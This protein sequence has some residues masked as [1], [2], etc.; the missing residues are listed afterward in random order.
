MFLANDILMAASTRVFIEPVV[1]TTLGTGVVAPGIVTITPPSMVAIYNGAMMVVDFGHHS[2]GSEQEV[3][4][5]SNVTA[6]TFQATF[7][8]P[9]LGSALL[10][11]GTFPTG[12]S[13]DILFTQLEVLGYLTDVV[14]DFLLKTRPISNIIQS[15]FTANIPLYNSPPDAIRIE[16]I[17]RQDSANKIFRLWDA[18]I[19]DLDCKNPNWR[20]VTGKPNMWYE[21]QINV[22]QYGIYPLPNNGYVSN[23]WYSQLNASPLLLNSPLLVPDVMADIP[24]YGMLARMFGK[25]GELRDPQRQSYCKQ[26]YDI[27]VEIVVRL[28]EGLKPGVMPGPVNQLA[29]ATA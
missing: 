12:Q 22:G 21:D 11:G 5:A 14:N 28:F 15:V 1:N 9:H 10:R 17:S 8:Y 20:G 4:T 27:G 19:T 26:R 6:T 25:D 24:Y 3:I 13:V 18:S 16:R 2:S 29:G 7:H 23:I